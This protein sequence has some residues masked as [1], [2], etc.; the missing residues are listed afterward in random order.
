M[1]VT[2]YENGDQLRG[3]YG[4][5]R[6]TAHEGLHAMRPCNICDHDRGEVMVPRG[7]EGR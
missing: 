4:T 3:K 7:E 5:G 6:P 2:S 1:S